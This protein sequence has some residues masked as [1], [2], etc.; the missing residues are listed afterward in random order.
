M[1]AD[2][3]KTLTTDALDRLGTLLDAGHSDQLTAFTYTYAVLWFSSSF[4]LT[5][6]VCACLYIFVAR[7]R[8]DERL[9]ALPPYPAP[10]HRRDLCLVLGEQHHR[11]SPGRAAA[12]TWLTIPERGLYTGTFIVGAIGSGKTSA[13]MYPYVEQLLA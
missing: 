5:S 10:E 8:R 9:A 3:L 7:D 11:T 4:F 13:R 6:A 2:A 1:Q 12:P